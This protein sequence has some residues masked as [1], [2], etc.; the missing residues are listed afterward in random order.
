M[1]M[2]E[3]PY[4]APR[5][6]DRV[7]GIK[8]GKREDLRSVALYQK[9]IMICILC[10][11]VALVAQVFLQINAKS[12]VS[13]VLSLI[14]GLLALAVVLTGVVFT[15]LLAIKVY[16]VAIGI[17]LGIGTM[18]PCIGLIVLLAVSNRATAIL[19]ENGI[20]V[21]F[22]GADLNTIA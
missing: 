12:G 1:S 8:S 10:Y 2:S 9:A 19:R 5:S 3:N 11:I 14:V 21:G 17:I 20:Q 22:L 4:E 16:N 13:A 18:I 15:F 7:V 6:V